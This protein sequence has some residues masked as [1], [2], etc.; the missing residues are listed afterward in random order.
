VTRWMAICAV[1]PVTTGRPSAAPQPTLRLRLAAPSDL[2]DL[3]GLTEL[4]G[5]GDRQVRNRGTSG[6]SLANNDPAAGYPAAALALDATIHTNRRRIA[7][8][9]FLCGLYETALQ[10]SFTP[11]SVKNLALNES[12]LASDLHAGA[13]YRAHPIRV[14]A[15]RCVVSC[16]RAS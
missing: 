7:A 14:L 6:G 4:R 5:I 1:A 3:S 16:L 13:D 11:A 9:D 12:E 2:I 10:A 8:A 15:G